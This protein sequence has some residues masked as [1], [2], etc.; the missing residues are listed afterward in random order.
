MVQEDGG[1]TFLGVDGGPRHTLEPFKSPAAAGAA[2]TQFQDDLVQD[3]LELPLP[4][5][6]PAVTDLSGCGEPL[7]PVHGIRSSARMWG[8]R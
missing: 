3:D 5:H 7:Y 8:S 4:T 6:P 2:T 1:L